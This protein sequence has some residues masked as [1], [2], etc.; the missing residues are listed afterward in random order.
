[1]KSKVP[2]DSGISD[3]YPTNVTSVLCV[4]PPPLFAK[5]CNHTSTPKKDEGKR[6]SEV[7]GKSE[8]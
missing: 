1:M 6:Q 8:T 3:K 4:F 2:S 7:P 5:S